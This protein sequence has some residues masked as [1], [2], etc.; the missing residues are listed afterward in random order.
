M[1]L[2]AKLK[3]LMRLNFFFFLLDASPASK[4]E[5]PKHFREEDVKEMVS[6][7]LRESVGKQMN[8]KDIDPMETSAA[9]ES[10]QV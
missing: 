1:G 8:S 7:I 10:G 4:S 3:H 9:G 2:D 6:K 5:I